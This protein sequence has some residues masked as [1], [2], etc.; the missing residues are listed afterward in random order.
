MIYY[1]SFPRL[2]KL[3]NDNRQSHNSYFSLPSHLRFRKMHQT[4]RWPSR[5]NLPVVVVRRKRL[6]VEKGIVVQ[7]RLSRYSGSLWMRVRTHRAA[8]SGAAH[9]RRA[10]RLHTSRPHHAGRAHRMGRRWMMR[11]ADHVGPRVMG[12]GRGS[13]APHVRVRR[14]GRTAHHSMGRHRMGTRRS[15][16]EMGRRANTVRG[17][18]S[19]VRRRRRRLRRRQTRRSA[20]ACAPEWRQWAVGHVVELRERCRRRRHRLQRIRGAARRVDA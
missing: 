8:G 2:S 17:R 1:N 15:A 12:M 7:M 4:Y 20:R 5:V 11:R 9:T 10:L 13:A 19:A 18:R 16:V 14:V 3:R 6:T